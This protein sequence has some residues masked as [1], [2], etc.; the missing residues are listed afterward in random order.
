MLAALAPGGEIGNAFDVPGLTPPQ[1]LLLPGSLQV[2]LDETTTDA[3]LA[4]QLGMPRDLNGDGDSLDP[5]VTLSATMLPVV[6]R[7]RWTG[8]TGEQEITLPLHLLGL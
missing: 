1:G 8:A 6:I 2:V 5:D 7:V 4:V 3:D